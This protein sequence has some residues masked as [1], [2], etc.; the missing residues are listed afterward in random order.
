MWGRTGTP[1]CELGTR[2]G[3]ALGL[4]ASEVGAILW[5]GRSEGVPQTSE[6]RACWP[7]PYLRDG[8]VFGRDEQLITCGGIYQIVTVV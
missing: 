1:A 5:P 4:N 7:L 3:V 6:V 8:N 2:R